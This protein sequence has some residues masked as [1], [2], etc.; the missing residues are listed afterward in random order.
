MFLLHEIIAIGS[1]P[2]AL[3]SCFIMA[4]GRRIR[5][6]L[7][8]QRPQQRIRVAFAR[9][10]AARALKKVSN[11]DHGR[12]VRKGRDRQRPPACLPAAPQ[13]LKESRA[14]THASHDVILSVMAQ[15][16]SA[17]RTLPVLQGLQRISLFS[18]DGGSLPLP[19]S[20]LQPAAGLTAT[21]DEQ[22]V[23]IVDTFR[24]RGA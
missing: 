24:C 20:D 5:W 2:V 17:G 22:T 3:H 9:A 4:L 6:R 10:S 14:S 23:F 16:L 8:P 12:A 15:R 18:V 7:R 21:L 1:S 11:S 19:L 13:P